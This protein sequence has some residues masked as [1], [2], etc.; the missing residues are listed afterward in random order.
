MIVSTT[1]EFYRHAH[2]TKNDPAIVGGRSQKSPLS[3]EGESQ[4]LKLNTYLLEQRHPFAALYASQAIRAI[5]TTKTAIKGVATLPLIELAGLNELSQG[6]LE[7]KVRLANFVPLVNRGLDDKVPGGQSI[8]EVGHDMR[9]AMRQICDK[10]P[11]SLVMVVGH[12]HALRA[13]LT[14]LELADLKKHDT[15]T[16]QATIRRIFSLKI[17]FCS[18]TTII[19]KGNRFTV[20]EWAVP[21]IKV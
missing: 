2:S 19:G 18:R 10:H 8:R 15:A 6:V 9:G 12:A 1:I 20:K 5:Q 4:A 7:G 3:T 16:V 13:F 17:P 11:S 14:D 21:T